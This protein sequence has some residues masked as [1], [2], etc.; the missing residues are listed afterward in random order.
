MDYYR[1]PSFSSPGADDEGAPR[2]T[3]R[4]VR[5]LPRSR[6]TR[7]RMLDAVEQ[8]M[9]TQ[10]S[11]HWAHFR[12][13]VDALFAAFPESSPSPSGSSSSSPSE[14][15][16]T[17]TLGFFASVAAAFALGSL[18]VERGDA[19]PAGAGSN[20]TSAP[21]TAAS[22][23]WTF[24]SSPPSTGSSSGYSSFGHFS[25]DTE[26]PSYGLAL[27]ADDVDRKDVLMRSAAEPEESC[28]S[29]SDSA[30]SLYALSVHTL[31]IAELA[32]GHA[33]DLDT[34]SG[35]ILQ[36]LYL[37]HRPGG[38]GQGLPNALLPLVGKLVSVART[39][40]LASDPDEWKG[41][42]GV[43]E[44]EMRRRAWWDVYYYDVFVSDALGHPPLIADDTHTT[45]MPAD[46][47]EAAFGPHC[48]S[49]PIPPP[50]RAEDG[51]ASS[52][53]FGLKCKEA[54]LVKA[55]KK[56]VY[57]DVLGDK[58]EMTLEEAATI[59]GEV[60]QWT[61]DLPPAFR[62]SLSAATDATNPILLAQQCEL[63]IVASSLILKLYL[64]F[65]KTRSSARARPRPG[66]AVHATLNAAHEIIGASKALYG[67]W[68]Q[69]RP[70][71]FGFYDFGKSV[72]GAAVVCAHALIHEPNGMLAPAATED[73]RVALEILRDPLVS[74]PS[75]AGDGTHANE[76]VRVIELMLK[77]ADDAKTGM[78]VGLTFHPGA[79]RKRS[80]AEDVLGAGF[81][82]PYVGPGAMV[83]AAEPTP[84]TTSVTTVP[85][86][87]TVS[88][89]TSTNSAHSSSTG[90][91]VSATTVTIREAPP[92]PQ[93][94]P[95]AADQAR[96]LLVPAASAVSRPRTGSDGKT[97][98]P[99]GIR[100]RGKEGT[101]YSRARDQ[102]A[103]R[104]QLQ[105]DHPGAP[106]PII[107]PSQRQLSSA[108]LQST[109]A[110]E[111]ATER[112]RSQHGAF[113]PPPPHNS[114]G[115]SLASSTASAQ[116]TPT[117]STLELPFGEAHVQRQAAGAYAQ[118]N[119]SSRASSVFDLQ[120]TSRSMQAAPAYAMSVDA[121]GQ[122]SASESSSPYDNGP[123]APQPSPPTA[124]PLRQS[125][126]TYGDRQPQQ[127]QQP[128]PAP[129]SAPL[130][131][132]YP[133]MSSYAPQER[134]PDASQYKDGYPMMGLGM[135]PDPAG[136]EM[137]LTPR[138]LAGSTYP[139]QHQPQE[140]G[141]YPS[142]P[143]SAQF[144]RPGAY[145]DPHAP[146]PPATTWGGGH[147]GWQQQHAP[148]EYKFTHA[149]HNNGW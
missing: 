148:N 74:P 34:V 138:G 9:K 127:P 108:S 27:D 20:S 146:P 116:A 45:K 16:R 63:A 119:A 51:D 48:T 96:P 58:G 42:Y 49:L 118:E 149:H 35:M 107:V 134:Q 126:P 37:L 52:A 69:T 1:A 125:P 104:Q 84:V 21:A 26:L 55:I 85:P 128:Q 105:S 135:P 61:K 111:S 38:P 99:I 7:E 87:A 112:T 41:R 40:G 122:R 140:T 46:V 53:F 13:R 65:L 106:P 97:R 17:T 75:K 144:A 89:S 80:E 147:D 94:T 25:N 68:R 142:P 6:A 10:P 36:I 59:E 103:Q 139:A 93:P 124:Y 56:R 24:T 4:L 33:Y 67:V 145:D 98:P 136:P 62:L 3:S 121:L 91:S 57:R 12:R 81:Q 71:A 76:A 50:L 130:Q 82:L 131:Q 117:L 83:R 72:F 60:L 129:P 31:S 66:Q 29:A 2:V 39:M 90:T 115:G 32:P 120:S 79:K 14:E 44:A 137:Q 70:A 18:L 19:A 54:Q 141:M 143:E 109:P 23:G 95:Q 132:G 113:P 15:P 123:S 5:L 28:P 8:T 73:V 114:Y 11:F 101:V 92:V 30:G 43:F 133:Y 47:D 86:S 100:A 102:Q 64:P 77:K 78:A 22:S 110:P 88:P